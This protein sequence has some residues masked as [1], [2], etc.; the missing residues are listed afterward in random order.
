MDNSL[1]NGTAATV[2]KSPQ[3]KKHNYVNVSPEDEQRP[4]ATTQTA[5]SNQTTM[6]DK[7]P[8]PLPRS[9]ATLIRPEDSGI[10]AS[11]RSHSYERIDPTKVKG[12]NNPRSSNEPDTP[13]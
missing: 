6:I 4:R 12:N 9:A 7:R 10:P 8:M 5:S 13:Q 2:E 1:D 11:R 3:I